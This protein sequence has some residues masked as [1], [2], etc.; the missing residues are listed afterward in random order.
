MNSTKRT[1]LGMIAALVALAACGGGG[2]G[3]GTS[4]AMNGGGGASGAAPVPP[5]SPAPAPAVPPPPPPSSSPNYAKAVFIGNSI[6]Y[7]LAS[8]AMGWDHTSG[9]AA[10]SAATDYAHLVAAALKVD[11]PNITN[12]SPLER[13]P[14]ANIS[15]IAEVTAP[16]DASTAVT[17]E[18]GDNVPLDK[19]AE[20]S[21]AYNALLDAI[22]GK[23]LVCVSTWWVEPSRDAVIKSACDAHGGKFVYIGD[24]RPDPNNRDHL[25]GPQYADPAVEDHPH[26]WSMARIAERV[27]AEQQN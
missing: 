13:N 10:S 20:F 16:I 8:P 5:P 7:S 22:H 6:T 23:S 26:D 19:L 21:T 25:D 9:M 3:G 27:I 1:K 17:V 24:V 15:G 18:L 4:T 12:F 14:S 11:S 2:E